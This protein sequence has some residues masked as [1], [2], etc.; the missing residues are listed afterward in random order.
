MALA[1]LATQSL[2]IRYEEL[3]AALQVG[4]G[5]GGGW[6]WGRGVGG[7]DQGPVC[8]SAPDAV[9]EDE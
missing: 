5:V 7:E 8:E 3:A 9:E 2:E 6:G 4:V 1:A